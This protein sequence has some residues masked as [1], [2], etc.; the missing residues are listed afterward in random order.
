MNTLLETA[1]AYASDALPVLPLFEPIEGA[2]ACRRT[3]CG[4][5]AK[6]PRTLHGLDDA[7]LGRSEIREWWR[8]WPESNIGVRTGTP[9]GL[10]VVDLDGPAARTALAELAA[11]RPVEGLTVRT[12]RGWQRW[13]RAPGGAQIP[14]SAGALGRGIDVRGHRGYAVA[15]P[16]LHVTGRRYRFTGGHL[17]HPPTWLVTLMVRQRAAASTSAP[18]LVVPPLAEELPH[19]FGAAVLARRCNAVRMAPEGER[20]Y[21]LLRA[22]TTCGGYIATGAIDEHDART[23]L[24]AAAFEIGLPERESL[25]TIAS[26][27][28]RG[29]QRPLYVGPRGDGSTT[30]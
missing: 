24:R 16:S 21:A 3:D 11:G 2:C 13:Y 1:L 12:G 20:N 9:G 15:P 25:R 27:F 30:P 28:E 14:N 22:S 5:P 10:V 8:R 23:A 26:G 7:T 19:R 18:G 17:G 6:H 4:S 29:R